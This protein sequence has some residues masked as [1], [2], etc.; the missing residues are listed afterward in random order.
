M[1]DVSFHTM[2]NKIFEEEEGVI[3]NSLLH[4]AIHRYTWN[5]RYFQQKL[6]RSNVTNTF[7]GQF[8]DTETFIQR[9]YRRTETNT[10][11]K[12]YRDTDTAIS[13]LLL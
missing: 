11:L 7:L 8:F 4:T 1:K 2:A 3:Y 10:F 5:L 9:L 12:K 6:Y 13:I